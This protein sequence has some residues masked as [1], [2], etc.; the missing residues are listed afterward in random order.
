MPKVA[1]FKTRKGAEKRRDDLAANWPCKLFAVVASPIS[2]GFRI[3]VSDP[4]TPDK[5]AYLL[6]PKT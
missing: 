1:E 2:F 6:K 5:I 4:A 3:S